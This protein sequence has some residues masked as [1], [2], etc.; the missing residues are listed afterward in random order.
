MSRQLRLTK[1]EYRVLVKTKQGYEHRVTYDTA[2]Q[3]YRHAVDVGTREG[4]TTKVMYKRVSNPDV[5]TVYYVFQNL[6][7]G[8][9]RV[10]ARVLTVDSAEDALA[11]Y[12]ELY[13]DL[14][15]N[16]Y[17]RKSVEVK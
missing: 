7:Y 13:P 5:H 12:R 2:D 15:N 4:L 9:R 11:M 8:Q 14:V 16:F 17:V 10:W 1:D 6:P 3:A